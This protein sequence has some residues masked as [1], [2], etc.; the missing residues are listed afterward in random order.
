M[1]FREH[2]AESYNAR[3]PRGLADYIWKLRDRAVEICKC[4]IAGPMAVK[5]V[6]TEDHPLGSLMRAK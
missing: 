1:N 3:E 2:C 4:S 6:R 5:S